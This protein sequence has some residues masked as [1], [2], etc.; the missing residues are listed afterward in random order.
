MSTLFFQRKKVHGSIDWA[1]NKRST[2]FS[3]YPTMLWTFLGKMLYKVEN[4]V[5]NVMMTHPSITRYFACESN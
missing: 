5:V 3:L 2:L 1:V 4:L